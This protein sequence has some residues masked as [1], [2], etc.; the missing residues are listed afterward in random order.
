MMIEVRKVT[1]GVESDSTRT[2]V[3]QGAWWVARPKRVTLTRAGHEQVTSSTS[4]LAVV[5]LALFKY[6]F[7][8]GGE[9]NGVESKNCKLLR[10][11]SCKISHLV[12]NGCVP[13]IKGDNESCIEAL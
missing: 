6:T 2:C 12:L 3:S 13:L 7:N 1:Q 9:Q 8:V 10:R 4:A 5:I 11:S